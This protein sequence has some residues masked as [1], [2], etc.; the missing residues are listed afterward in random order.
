MLCFQWTWAQKSSSEIES[1]KL[2]FSI[3]SIYSNSEIDAK[4][5]FI[6]SN[7]TY[8]WYNSNVESGPFEEKDYEFLYQKTES[9]KLPI[10]YVSFGISAQK[11]LKNGFYQE[12]GISRFIFSR[13]KIVSG[14]TTYYP[15]TKTVIIEKENSSLVIGLRYEFGK[16]F[17]LGQIKFGGSFGIEPVFYKILSNE[18]Q[19]IY[20]PYLSN[21]NFSQF[22]INLSTNPIIS[23]SLNDRLDLEMKYLPHYAISI[24][25]KTEWLDPNYQIE[26]INLTKRKTIHHASSITLKFHLRPGK[27][28]GR[29]AK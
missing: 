23:F 20:N 5:E 1:W 26:E 19:G 24:A 10:T 22:D 17:Q 2:G 8:L 25:N 3:N 18:L 12:L 21:L 16:L 9:I 14:E 27:T 4:S 29:R 7:E 15:S 11:P 28:K 6:L 13:E